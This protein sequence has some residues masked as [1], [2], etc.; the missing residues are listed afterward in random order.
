M[1][2]FECVV[3]I[4]VEFSF[5]KSLYIRILTTVYI[6]LCV[7]LFVVWLVKTNNLLG[8]IVFCLL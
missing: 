2:H 6:K 1:V 8:E 5:A 3:W 4:R 7:E